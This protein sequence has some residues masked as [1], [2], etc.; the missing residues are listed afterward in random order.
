VSGFVAIIADR[1]ERVVREEDL[2]GFIDAWAAIHGD[3]GAGESVKAQDRALACVFSRPHEGGSRV[4]RR[5]DSWALSA[6]VPYHSGPLVDASPDEL[7]GQFAVLRYDAESETVTLVSDPL[8][9]FGLFVASRDGLT[10]ASTSALAL[11][12]HVGAAPSRLG[13]HTYLVAGYHCGKRTSWEGVE[14]LEGGRAMCFGPRGASQSVY[15]R[16]EVD[17]AVRGLGLQASIDRCIDSGIEAV[18]MAGSGRELL[19]C[20]L[21]GGYD[22]RMLSLLARAAGLRFVASTNGT[23]READA[24]LARRVAE[25]GGWEWTLFSLPQTWPGM[26]P[27]RLPDGVGWGDAALDASQLAGVLWF[28]KIKSER[29]RGVLNGGGGE[30]FWSCAWQHEYGRSGRSGRTDL[31]TWVRVRMIR[32]PGLFSVFARDPRPEVIADLRARMERVIEPYLGQPRTL[33][34]DVLYMYKLTGHFGAYASAAAAHVDLMM[35]FYSRASFGTVISTNP[36]YRFGKQFYRRLIE[37]LDPAVAAVPT[38]QGGP[39]RPRRL[40]NVHAFMPYYV[41]LAERGLNKGAH[42]FLR[43]S[44]RRPPT[45]GDHG[46]AATRAAAV[47]Y[48]GTDVRRWHTQALYDRDELSGMLARASRTDFAQSALLGRILTAELGL[49]RVGSAVE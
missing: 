29:A 16:P 15:W 46:A 31:D 45:L 22:T 25:V 27:E 18:R 43:R 44:F 48:V 32:S 17:E 12:R 20:D 21:T 8:G 38:S 35:P 19:W 36:R 47:S 11:A 26:L 9:M 33:Q 37:R 42:L 13:L 4:E 30:H 2:A 3:G 28:H 24:Q 39:A 40:A 5:G 7:D 34:A 10:Y 14:R 41:G 49:R 6:G 23:G 1:A